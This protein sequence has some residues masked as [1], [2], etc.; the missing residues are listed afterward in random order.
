MLWMSYPIR[1]CEKGMEKGMNFPLPTVHAGAPWVRL[2]RC[3]M[4]KLEVISLDRAQFY[5]ELWT[6]NGQELRIRYALSPFGL[7]QLCE[8]HRLPVPP[9]DYWIKVRHGKKVKRRPLPNLAD[10]QFQTIHLLLLTPEMAS[11]KLRHEPVLVPGALLDP[12]RSVVE[13]CRHLQPDGA[14]DGRRSAP[15]PAVVEFHVSRRSADRALR[16]LNPLI[17]AFE[18]DRGQLFDTGRGCQRMYRTIRRIGST[19]YLRP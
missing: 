6:L 1:G 3:P 7:Q 19:T 15:R 8:K 10:P 12:H 4:A 18:A 14:A 13:L 17:K 11:C 16:V 9:A 2:G 5:D